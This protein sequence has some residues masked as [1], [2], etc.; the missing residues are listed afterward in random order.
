MRLNEDDEE[1]MTKAQ[2]ASR[3]RSRKFAEQQAAKKERDLQ[4]AQDR[5]RKYAA[6]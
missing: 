5:K 1:G 4:R 2:L 6:R 3:E